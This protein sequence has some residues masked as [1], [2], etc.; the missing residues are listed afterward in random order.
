MDMSRNKLQE[1]SMT[2]I[3]DTL[4]YIDMGKEIDI[5]SLISNYF[6][7]PIEDCDLYIKEVCYN[8]ILHFN[9]IV[10]NLNNYTNKWKFGRLNFLAQAILLLSYSHFYYVKD[11]NKSIIIDIAIKLAKKYLDD[12]D[13][14]YINAILDRALC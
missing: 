4:L 14:K 1:A 3:Y 13:Y 12:G 6:D 8:V 2:I 10:E 7:E 5:K 11:S 9:E